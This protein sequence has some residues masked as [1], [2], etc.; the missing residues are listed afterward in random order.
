MCWH[1]PATPYTFTIRDSKG[2]RGSSLPG[3]NQEQLRST[4]KKKQQHGTCHS[5]VIINACN[6]GHTRTKENSRNMEP[7][8]RKMCIRKG[9]IWIAVNMHFWSTPICAHASGPCIINGILSNFHRRHPCG[10]EANIAR[11]WI[12]LM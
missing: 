3:A 12:R 10:Y 7:I 2:D 6:S 4:H 8:L 11:Y 1:I 9:K 5:C